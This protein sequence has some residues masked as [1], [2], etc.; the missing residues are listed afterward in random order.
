MSKSKKVEEQKGPIVAHQETMRQMTY[1]EKVRQQ[2]EE[3]GMRRGYQSLTLHEP[4]T[5]KK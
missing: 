3:N 4:K 5:G 2:K 1:P